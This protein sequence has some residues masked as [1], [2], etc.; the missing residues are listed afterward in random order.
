ME[1]LERLHLACA[2]SANTP[3]TCR[4]GA[5]EICR[6]G[7]KRTAPEET[8]SMSDERTTIVETT[9]AYSGAL[10]GAIAV[11]VLAALG[12][13]VWSYALSNRIARQ[14]TALSEAN[15]ESA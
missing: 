6:A 13:L 12:G 9:P 4:G 5:E 1:R 7:S 14:E 2:W 15:Q 10:L 11:A 8:G 3:Q